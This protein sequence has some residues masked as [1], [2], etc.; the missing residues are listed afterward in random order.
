MPA[1]GK[2]FGIL[3]VE[4]DSLDA[5]LLQG[6]FERYGDLVDIH[7]IENG[8]E[9]LAQ[10]R[11]LVDDEATRR[12]HLIIIDV[13]LPDVDGAKLYALCSFSTG[14]RGIPIVI[15]TGGDHEGLEGCAV[16]DPRTIYMRKPDSSYGYEKA[17]DRMLYHAAGYIAESGFQRA[18]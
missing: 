10:I 17:A 4:D 12:P 7:H 13:S 16:S 11:L 9:A 5:T 18:G 1:S 2:S 14:S 3:L 15:F 6:A 8:E